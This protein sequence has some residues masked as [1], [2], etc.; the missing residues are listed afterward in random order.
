MTG[1]E[2]AGISP[3]DYAG[4]G[5]AELAA[6]YL[7]V[8]GDDDESA[9]PAQERTRRAL[10]RLALGTALAERVVAG[11]ALDAAAALEAC[12]TWE[13]VARARGRND[14][15]TVRT[16]FAAWVRAAGPAAPRHWS[17]TESCRGAG[18]PATT[19]PPPR[20]G[21]GRPAG[22]RRA[23]PMTGVQKKAPPAPAGG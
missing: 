20:G 14:P 19:R 6:R 23:G 2:P 21:P 9:A 18:G 10:E 11:S 7:A 1:P 16:E 22:P 12:A 3:G 13:L 17:R 4:M 15:T 8:R 5:L